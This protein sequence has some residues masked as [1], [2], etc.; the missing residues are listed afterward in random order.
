MGAPEDLKNMLEMSKAMIDQLKP[1]FDTLGITMEIDRIDISPEDCPDLCID[2]VYR[3]R[4]SNKE[5][6]D[7]VKERLKSG[8]SQ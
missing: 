6:C 7:K 2:I 3:F 8:V 1:Y 4:C 5:V